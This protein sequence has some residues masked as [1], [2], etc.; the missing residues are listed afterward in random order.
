MNRGRTREVPPERKTM[1][2]ESLSGVFDKFGC[3]CG[4]YTSVVLPH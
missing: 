4:Q 3:S 1:G 2:A